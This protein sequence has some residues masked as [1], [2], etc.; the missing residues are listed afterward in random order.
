MAQQGTRTLKLSILADIDQLT[1]NLKAG[2][3]DV[4]TFGDKIADYGK[5]V[6]AAFLA[7]G[8]AAAAYA[9]KLAYDGV[10]AA[11]QDQAAQEKLATTL[12]NVTGA[13]DEAI[14]STEDFINRL[15]LATG[16]A[17][18]QLRPAFDRLVRSGLNL[19]DAQ[20]VLTTA[21]DVSAGTGKGLEA[22]ANALGKAY[23]GNT[24][25]LGRLGLGLSSAELKAMSFDEIMGA[26]TATFKDQASIQAD[27]FQGKM[28]R[29]SLAFD[30]AKE[31]LGMQLLPIIEEFA[32]YLLTVV[33]P[34]VQK[35]LDEN[36]PKLVATIRDLIIPAITNMV[37]KFTTIVEWIVN[38]KDA[39]ASIGSILLAGLAA[40]KVT[41]TISTIVAAL[42][43]LRAA[44][45]ATSTAAAAA[46][47]ATTTAAAA[48]GTA[49]AAG[50]G[51]A[52][53]ISR[54]TPLVAV[55]TALVVAF[56]KIATNPKIRNLVE[57]KDI[58]NVLPGLGRT[59]GNLDVG[60]GTTGSKVKAT[61][62]SVLD[63]YQY[64]MR[65]QKPTPKIDQLPK[66]DDITKDRE[67]PKPDPAT[68]KLQETMDELRVTQY[69]VSNT[70][71]KLNQVAAQQ[72]TQL[73][74]Y[75]RAS[76]GVA[77]NFNAPVIS[78]PES[79]ARLVSDQLNASSS[80]T[81]NY[82][83]LGVSSTSLAQAAI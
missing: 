25:A 59:T 18:D 17:D 63:A 73:E 38:N 33:V 37:K 20:K 51:F 10:R 27:T 77:I 11:I 22:V 41:S 44:Y 54:L 56:E 43:T 58:E 28:T 34:A 21:L 15:A 35:W 74:M 23:E 42:G 49:A 57:N 12:R 53:L 45:L 13:T 82:P 60:T 80:R 65:M 26:L 39:I 81:G 55:V 68:V 24:T 4:E 72:L 83:T 9:G 79:L 71:D 8:A 19:S 3:K 76:T 75:D 62:A 5:K 67:K 6:G 1:K 2:S 32:D 52:A 50:G 7:A 36:G 30:E 78:D 40:A 61:G 48:A 47:T 29:I 46:G 64:Q 66:I 31:S 70:L 14:R 69:S 16:V